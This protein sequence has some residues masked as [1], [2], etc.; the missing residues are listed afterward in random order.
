MTVRTLKSDEARRAFAEILDRARFAAEVTVIT[1]YS[2]PVAVILPYEM[3][4][5]M[6][7]ATGAQQ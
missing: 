6:K 3:Y 4:E 1:R 2:K 5:Q 7:A